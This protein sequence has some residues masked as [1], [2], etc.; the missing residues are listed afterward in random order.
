MKFLNIE[1]LFLTNH[2]FVNINLNQ[3]YLAN[4]TLNSNVRDPSC[5]DKMMKSYPFILYGGYGENRNVVFKGT[6][7]D[8]IGYYHHLGIDINVPANEVII[9]PV[10]ATIVNVWLDINEKTGWGGRVSLQTEENKPYITL[11]H[12]DPESIKSLRVGEKVQKK[13]F[14]GLVGTWPSNGNV[15]EHLHL[16]LHW[17]SNFDNMD[18]YGFESELI[19]NPCPFTTEI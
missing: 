5:L 13:Q 3:F 10:D 4:K 11:A 12:F 8:K 15:F 16:Q 2:T 1:D 18:G 17:G 6:R 9:S 19:N 14:L 7:F